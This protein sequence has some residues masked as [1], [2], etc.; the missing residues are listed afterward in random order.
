[1]GS[2]P[3]RLTVLSC[4]NKEIGY[5]VTRRDEADG[6]TWDAAGH[7][8]ASLT[9]LTDA[10]GGLQ[11]GGLH[12]MGVPVVDLAVRVADACPERTGML[13][14]GPRLGWAEAAEC[15]GI[16]PG[17]PPLNN[18]GAPSTLLCQ[19]NNSATNLSYL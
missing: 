6:R 9:S 12:D 14:H 7:A 17:R 5:P 3:T 16:R 10:L 11:V 19:K 13:I 4:G 18:R 15:R 2:S 8:P 1:M